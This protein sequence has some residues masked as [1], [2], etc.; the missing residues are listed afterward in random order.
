MRILV[1][2]DEIKL[3][4][5]IARALKLQKY[6][7]DVVFDG[8]KGFNFA[9]G[10]EFDLLI[11]DINLPGMDGLEICR[12][13]RQE[14][15]HTP[16]LMLTARGQTTDKVTGLD[17]GADDYLVKPFSFEEL[18]AR[19]RALIRRP[20]KTNKSILRVKDLALDIIKFKVE[21]NN[22]PIALSA[23]EFSIL[24]YL[25]RHKNMVISRQQLIA[26]IWS[27]DADVLPNV[28]EVHIKHLRDK[29]DTPFSDK[30]IKTIRTK[31]YMIEKEK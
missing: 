25:L 28:V 12:K 30:L 4:N 22:Q 14:G 17:E 2:E 18:F 23:K 10:E 20:Q 9:V 7:V 26:H 29:I 24:E 13:I 15:L 3:A 6:A 31:G 11:L 8:I 21:R 1:V 27:Y 5:A 16:I 19:I